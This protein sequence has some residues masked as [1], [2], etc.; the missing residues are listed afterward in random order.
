MSYT[1]YLRRKAAAAPVILDPS[2]RKVDASQFTSVTRMKANSTFFTSSRVGVINNLQ[3][4]STTGTSRGSNQVLAYTK[5]AGGRVPD[6]SNYI[7]FVG[8][9]AIR[10]DILADKNPTGKYLLNSND[11]GSLS[12]C[13]PIAGPT[14]FT[15]GQFTPNNVPMTGSG[16][17]NN[18]K[19]CK[20]L[21]RVEP[22]VANELGPSLFVD[23]MRPAKPASNTC[24][25]GAQTPCKPVIHTHPAD[26]VHRRRHQ[27]RP[28]YAQKGIPNVPLDM[29]YKQ[30]GPVPSKHL[31]YVEKHHGNDLSVMVNGR[32]PV[33]GKFQIP[34][35]TPAHLKINDPIAPRVP[36]M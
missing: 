10:E 33:P 7:S 14:P 30:G 16:F 26:F 8:G 19:H 20:D 21:G 27:M 13:R 31:K 9:N 6:A 12:A 15:G 23:T 1:E 25:N 11:T 34:A 28:V 29:P 18:T 24:T 2:P 17:L 35:G 3:D 32:K 36:G 22:H 4:P 5:T